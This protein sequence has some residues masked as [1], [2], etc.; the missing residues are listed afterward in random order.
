LL[1]EIA[2]SKDSIETAFVICC[3]CSGFAVV[4]FVYGI[5]EDELPVP[6]SILI[7]QKSQKFPLFGLLFLV[8]PKQYVVL[9]F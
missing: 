7:D 1:V 5:I 4:P 3:C 9:L 6:F 2:E 8:L